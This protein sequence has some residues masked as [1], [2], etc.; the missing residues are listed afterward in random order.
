[1]IVYCFS[2]GSHESNQQERPASLRDSYHT[3]FALEILQ[4]PNKTVLTVEVQVLTGLGRVKVWW[5]GNKTEISSP[6]EKWQFA[7]RWSTQGR[8]EF[9]FFW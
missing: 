9:V 4:D 7:E 6:K 3:R 2:S 5:T 1:M 8:T